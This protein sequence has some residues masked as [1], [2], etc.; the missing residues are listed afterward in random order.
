M[1]DRPRTPTQLA[2]RQ[3]LSVGIASVGAVMFGRAAQALDAAPASG[4]PEP[5]ELDAE[6][7]LAWFDL[8]GELVRSTPGF[9]PPVAARAFGYIGV[10]LYEAVVSGMRHH[11]S[12]AGQLN[13]LRHP[14]A[15]HESRSLY[16][17]LVAN[18]ALAGAL[19]HLFPGSATDAINE[20]ELALDQARSPSLD[21]HTVVRSRRHGERVAATIGDWAASDGGHEGYLRNFPES[22]AP[23]T[24]AGAWEPTPPGFLRG[25][26]PTWGS[27]RPM[28]AGI[29]QMAPGAPPLSYSTDPQSAFYGQAHEVY[30]TVNSLT[31][32]Q[33]EIARFWSEDPGATATPAGHSVSIL[34]QILRA[35]GASLELAAEAYAK[36]GIALCDAFVC[37]WATKYRYNLLRPI[38]YIRANIDPGWGDPLPLT[39]PS[40]PEHTSGHSVQS[41]AASRVLTALFGPI[42]FTDHTHDHRGFAPRHFASLDHAAE[43]AAASRLYGGIHYRHAI[44]DGLRQ[45]RI[46]GDAVDQLR[47]RR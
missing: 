7:A 9:T 14:P 37:C 46:I 36:L 16:W 41:G 38:T 43:E 21:R 13:E 47:F 24:G 27:N 28:L 26:Q 23:P 19:R 44:E 11:R 30:E 29:A 10:T 32:Q 22:Y 45:G 39:T 18:A 17:P 5:A 33:L 20:H 2:R 4:L 35:R 1:I 8:A 6:V 12:L 15:A 3:F 25:L 42:A 40:F 31:P 34:T